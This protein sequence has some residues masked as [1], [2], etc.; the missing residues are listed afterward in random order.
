ML[1]GMKDGAA[2]MENTM[3]VN[4]ILKIVISHDATFH[5]SLHIFKKLK[6]SE[7]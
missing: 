3:K 2:A 6:I 5:F 7:R 4:K 1:V